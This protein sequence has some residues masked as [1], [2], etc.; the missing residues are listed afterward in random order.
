MMALS[1]NRFV[2]GTRGSALALVQAN[3]IAALVRQ[4][5]PHLEVEVKVIK[6][7]GD[8]IR[9]VALSKLGSKGL[10]TK[11]LELELLEGTIDCCVHSMKDVPTELPQGLVIGSMP[12]REDMRDVLVSNVG[13]TLE[14]LPSGARVGTGSLRRRAQLKAL[15][16]DLELVEL[17]GNLDTRLKKVEEGQLDAAILA[18]AGIK[19]MGW[20]ERITAY[21]QITDMVPAVGQGAIGVEIREED[22]FTRDI[23]ETFDHRPTHKSVEAERILMNALEGGCQVPMGA[24]AR[25]LPTTHNAFRIDAFVSSLDGSRMIKMGK[26]GPEADSEFVAKDLAFEL[27]KAGAAQLLDEVRAQAGDNGDIEVLY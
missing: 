3:Y 25:V 13:A 26:S 14:E 15:R 20:Q 9:D 16:P 23:V 11:E 24:F 10:F 8:K 4:A 12:L 7:T 6:T 5:R 27:L 21:L 1:R 19:R 18:A 2:I 22:L 17:R